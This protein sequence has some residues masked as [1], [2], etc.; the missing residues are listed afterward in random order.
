[1]DRYGS[2]RGLLEQLTG[3]HPSW[4]ERLHPSLPYTV[5][6]I[7]WGVR[8]EWARNL[9]DVLARRTRA[10]FLDAGA[11]RE[12]APGVAALMAAELGLDQAWQSRQLE[13]FNAVAAQYLPVER[14]VKKDRP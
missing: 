4:S 1:M 8:Y 10:L 3:E 11:S 7:V 13:S 2:D 5:G 14:A 9:E 6:E 12:I